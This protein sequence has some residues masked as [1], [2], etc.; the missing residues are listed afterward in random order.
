MDEDCWFWNFGPQMECV[1]YIRVRTKAFLLNCHLIT[2][3]AR[4]IILCV[5]CVCVPYCVTVLTNFMVIYMHI[6]IYIYIYI[7]THTHTYIHNLELQDSQQYRSS[8]PTVSP[9]IRPYIG[10]LCAK[11]Q[12]LCD[13]DVSS[14]TRCCTDWTGVGISRSNMLLGFC[15][16]IIWSLRLLTPK[17]RQFY[18]VSTST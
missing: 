15:D 13:T 7:Y 5:V 8:S 11:K 10:L 18:V 4:S 16:L 12:H 2:F 17:L 3:A 1:T 14:V 9:F 6:Y